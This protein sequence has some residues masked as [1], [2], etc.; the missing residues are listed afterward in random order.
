MGVITDLKDIE[1][2]DVLLVSTNG[3]LPKMIKWFQGNE[4]NHAGLFIWIWGRLFVAEANGH[5]IVFTPF[6]RDYLERKK[7]S[8]KIL[9]PMDKLAEYKKKNMCYLVAEL[10]DRGYDYKS[11]L[12]F[13]AV[14]F[15]WL[16]LTG[17]ELWLGKKQDGYERF[18]CGEFVAYVYND[19]KG[20]FND[21]WY[22][23]SPGEIDAASRGENA[24]FNSFSLNFLKK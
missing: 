23:I 10:T 5:G 6:K 15:L 7:M 24:F 21:I 19:V 20:Y 17:R 14:R 16:K 1:T 13:D 18:T 3:F 4:Y 2:G 9:K 11:L 12:F 8:L 22:K